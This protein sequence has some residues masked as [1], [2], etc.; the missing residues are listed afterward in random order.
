M[1]NII[2][3][4][5]SAISNA[6]QSIANLLPANN[7]TVTN[8]APPAPL[9]GTPSFSSLI[10]PVDPTNTFSPRPVPAA[11]QPALATA[12]QTHPNIPPGTLE[13]ILM[14]ESSMGTNPNGYN[15]NNGESSWLAGLTPAAAQ[16]LTQKN[17]AHNFNT[18]SGAIQGMANYLATRQSGVDDK[19]KPFNI[20]DP[21]QLYF[22]RYKT[23]S[24]NALP[25][26]PQAQK[27]F[28]AYVSYY[29]NANK[30]STQN[31][32]AQQ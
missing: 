17:I 25:T 9:P 1:Q 4:V 11:W 21:S 2:Q 5:T 23:A 16:D 24:P 19:G 13:A 18:Q 22:Q 27:N 15:K 20:T 10:K 8:N 7:V 26:S 6:G 14:Q 29:A 3:P 28:K 12:Y 32:L 30:Q 31:E